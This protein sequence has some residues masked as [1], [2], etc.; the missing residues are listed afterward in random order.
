MRPPGGAAAARSPRSHAPPPTHAEVLEFAGDDEAS[1]LFADEKAAEAARR[2]A[3]E[4]AQ[5]AAVPGLLNPHAVP[6]DLNDL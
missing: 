6:D 5:R 3:E 1:E 2:A 4:Q